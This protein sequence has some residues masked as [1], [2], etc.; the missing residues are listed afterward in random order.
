MK[1]RNRR[2]D[3][4]KNVITSI[5]DRGTDVEHFEYNRLYIKNGPTGTLTNKTIGGG[6]ENHMVWKDDFG[7]FH[8]DSPRGELINGVNL[9]TDTPI[10]TE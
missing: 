8:L 6:D 3:E 1:I 10:F 5:N 2:E 9:D 4:P 7:R